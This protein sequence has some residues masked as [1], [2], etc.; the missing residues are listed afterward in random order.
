MISA[1][2]LFSYGL[3]LAGPIIDK[4]GV[5]LAMILGLACYGFGKFL[6]I[7]V[8]TRAQLTGVMV[9]VLP[10][11]GSIVFPCTMLGVKK[12]TH[13]NGRPQGFSLFYA[14]MITGAIVGGPI[15]DLIRHDFK[16][17]TWEYSHYNEET[18]KDEV[19]FIEFSAWRTICFFG[20]VLNLI[21]QILLCFYDSNV[22]KRFRDENYD[23]GKSHHF[24]KY[25][26][27]IYFFH[28]RGN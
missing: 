8:D 13:E 11:G 15:V 22:E 10:F 6:L 5:K 12:L 9:T 4:M 27:L 14:A 24:F 17:S 1:L 16:Y 2:C 25:S 20:L 28:Y 19:R 23:Q 7:F 21:M 18:G 3:V 26:L